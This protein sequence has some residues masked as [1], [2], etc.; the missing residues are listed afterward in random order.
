MT[1]ALYVTAATLVYLGFVVLL[2]RF[3]SLSSSGDHDQ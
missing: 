1:T 3:L 2:G